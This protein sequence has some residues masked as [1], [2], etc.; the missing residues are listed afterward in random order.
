MH[1]FDRETDR[2]RWT[3]S[4]LLTRQPWIQCSAVKIDNNTLIAITRQITKHIAVKF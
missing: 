1:A 3:D 2:D 4:F